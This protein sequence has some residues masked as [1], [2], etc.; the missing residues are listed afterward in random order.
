MVNTDIRL[1]MFFAVISEEALYNQQKYNL[2]LT[3]A[4]I[5][6]SLMQNQA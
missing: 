4:Q 5:M 6:S 1:T 3:L 2:E